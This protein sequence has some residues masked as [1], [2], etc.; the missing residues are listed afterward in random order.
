M[1]RW[2]MKPAILTRFVWSL[3]EETERIQFQLDL[4]LWLDAAREQE[5]ALTGYSNWKASLS[6]TSTNISRAWIVKVY[7]F[8][9]EFPNVWRIKP[10]RLHKWGICN[11]ASPIPYCFY[12]DE[13]DREADHLP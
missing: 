11:G 3:L 5:V 8:E 10:S 1:E 13:A 12:S 6:I 9:S 4:F 7:Q 2:K